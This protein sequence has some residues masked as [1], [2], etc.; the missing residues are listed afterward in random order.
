MTCYKPIKGWRSRNLSDNGKF[1]FT[2][3]PSEAFY[4]L[5]MEVPCGRCI[6]CRIQ[7]SQQ[8]A[9]R[10]Y[11]E[12]QLYRQ[13]CFITL[14]FNEEFNKKTL[15]VKDF[16][17]FMK[18]LRKK[19]VPK[20]PYNKKTQ[21]EQYDEFQRKHSIRFFHCGEYGTVCGRCGLSEQRCNS[22]RIL[23]GCTGFTKD[24][25]RPHHHACVF[26]FD[27]PD[28]EIWKIKN[29][30]K[31]YRS[32]ELERLWSDPKTGKSYGYSTIGE[33]TFESAAYVAR[34]VL[35]KF[36]SKNE[37]QVNQHYKGKIPEYITM[38]R[39]PGIGKNWFTKFKEGV[40]PDDFVSIDS[41]IEQAKQQN[42]KPTI[43]ALRTTIGKGSPH[44]ANTA[45]VH[46]SPLGE[47]S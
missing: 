29:G 9:I 13:N 2:Q 11:H 8:W 26:N 31:L 32:R 33:V 7:R 19:Y 35:K 46:G 1:Y 38:S 6:G 3:K 25:G 15:T 21:K 44:K 40:Y 27:F 23:T 39:R 43:I 12:A 5:R 30:I 24:I 20:N 42:D 47:I 37:E 36:T 4:D 22:S 10:C 34:Y 18:R 41:A 14:T 45:G 28:K 16:Q 17:L